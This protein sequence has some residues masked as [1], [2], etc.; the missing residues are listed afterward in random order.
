MGHGFSLSDFLDGFGAGIYLL[1][2]IIQIDL[3]LRRRDRKA[4]L[5]LAIASSGALTIDLTGIFIIHT[6]GDVGAFVAFL[7]LLGA[8]VTVLSLLELIG[9]LAQNPTRI[10]ER[11]TGA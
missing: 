5:L 8:A 4:H 11:I 1:F 7:N 2:F 10:I 3:W 9:I 6:E